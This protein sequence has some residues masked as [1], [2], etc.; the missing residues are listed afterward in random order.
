MQWATNNDQNILERDNDNK[1][2]AEGYIEPGKDHVTKVLDL[3]TSSN[4]A[5][6][7]YEVLPKYKGF[8]SYRPGQYNRR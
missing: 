1:N 7:L 5:L 4:N 2:S 8:Q 6:Y 3:C